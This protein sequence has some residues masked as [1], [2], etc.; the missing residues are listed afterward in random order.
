MLIILPEAVLLAAILSISTKITSC[1]CGIINAKSA[2]LPKR[3]QRRKMQ[4]ATKNVLFYIFL[5]Q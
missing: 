2:L 3:S 5:Y 1:P 4:P